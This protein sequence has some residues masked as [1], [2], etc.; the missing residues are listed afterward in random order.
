[1]YLLE[2]KLTLQALGDVRSFGHLQKNNNANG[3]SAKMIQN[4]ISIIKSISIGIS[5]II[6]VSLSSIAAHGAGSSKC[7]FEFQKDSLELQFTGYKFTNKTGVHGTFK[8]IEFTQ[9]SE[10]RSLEELAKSLKFKIDTRSLET[11]NPARNKNIV[12]N[13]FKKMNGG[14]EIT[15]EVRSIDFE[16]EKVV[17]EVNMHGVKANIPLQVQNTNQKIEAVGSFDLMEAFKMQ[18]PYESIAKSCEK[19]HTGE[20]GVSKTWTEVGIRVAANYK[21]SCAP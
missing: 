1:M 15:G 11:E 10:S 16:K 2:T 4:I 13:F 14:L 3:V 6:F 19:L 8:E 20:D 17:F 9:D 12:A 5:S 7:L 21:N 18:R